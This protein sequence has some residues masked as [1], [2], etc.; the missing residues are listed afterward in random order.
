M[1]G[2]Y[3]VLAV[4]NVGGTDIPP[5]TPMEML[6]IEGTNEPIHK[7]QMPS[8]ASMNQLLINGPSTL[9]SGSY[10][11]IPD[12]WPRWSSFSGAT[13]PTVGG[14]VGAA[15]GTSGMQSGLTGFL[16]LAIHG[17]VNAAGSLALDGATDGGRVLVRPM[18]GGG[19][20]AITVAQATA[21][22]S[23]GLVSVKAVQ[24]TATLSA[25]PNFEQT[26][27]AITA[28]YFKL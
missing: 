24:F 20:G 23:A 4:H 26:G 12:A 19:G 3:R 6:G 14:Q 8:A 28:K 16:C 17:T 11:A 22:G 5:C 27:D 18:G 7:V 21:D 13:Q 2:G 9:Y 15:A 25:S 10:D 1:D